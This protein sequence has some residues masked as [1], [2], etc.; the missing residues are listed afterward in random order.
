MLARSLA[1]LALALPAAGPAFAAD[2]EPVTLVTAV[3]YGTHLPGLGEPAVS[4]A[5]LLKERSGGAVTLDLKQPGDG[6]KPDE[7]LDKVSSG[8]IDAGFAPPGLW[9]AK[10]PAAP[11]FSG[12][13]FGPDAKLYLD[14]F[15]HGDGR[16]L[17]Q[18]MYDHAGIKVHVMPCAFGGAETGGWFKKQIAAKADI[19]GLRMRIFGLG[20]RVMSRLGATPVLVPGGDVLAAFAAGKIDAAEL[21]PPAVDE[22]QG[23]TDKIKLIYVPGWHQP[24]TVLELL[25]NKDRWEALSDYQRGLIQGACLATLQSTLAGNVKLEAD[26][27]AKIA[28]AGV[29]IE[30]W[31]D[32]VLAALRSAWAE[33][34]KEEG[35]RDYFFRT[36]F[37]DIETFRI[38]STSAPAPNASAE[39]DASAEA[40]AAP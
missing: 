8:A 32:D 18:E 35:D 9:A 6:T 28:N 31:P 29:R 7:I 26:A 25:I 5:K 16:K 38:K 17:D 36:V 33:I 14:W 24:E 30:P 12:F 39:P 20:A 37:D 27:M 4:L 11:L 2:A 1:M 13:P 23:L 10:L 3:A 15:E 40:K 21:Y 19:D 22:R 34:A